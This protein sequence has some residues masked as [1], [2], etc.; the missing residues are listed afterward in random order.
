MTSDNAATENE[1]LILASD[2]RALKASIARSL[3]RRKVRA[4]LLIAPLLIFVLLSFIFPIADMLFRSVE[5]QIVGDVLP[6]T[7]AILDNQ[8]SNYGTVPEEDV[9]EALMLDVVI[10][11]ELKSHTRLGSRLNYEST[12]I[13]S[14]FTTIRQE[15]K[16]DVL[17]SNK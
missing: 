5:N 4:L 13:S 10:A 1:G 2:G 16:C 14:T 9:F 11:A 6:R 7:V 12:G 15:Q 3:F 17:I 8:D